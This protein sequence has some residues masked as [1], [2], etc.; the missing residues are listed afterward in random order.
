M[1]TQFSNKQLARW[2]FTVNSLDDFELPHPDHMLE[3]LTGVAADH[4]VYQTEKAT[5]YHYQG[6]L[7]LKK[8]MTKKSLLEAWH[9][10][11]WPM[12]ALTLSIEHSSKGAFNYCTKV[13]TRVAGPFSDKPDEV[14]YDGCDLQCMEVPFP[15]QQQVLDEVA[16]PP[17]DRKILWIHEPT[18]NVGKSKLLKYMRFKGLAVRVP[19]GSA[20]QLRCAM[21]GKGTQRCYVVDLPRVRGKDDSLYD[22][23]AAIEELKNGWIESAFYGKAAELM[24]TPPHVIVVSNDPPRLDL[25]SQDRWA[26]KQIVDKQLVDWVAPPSVDEEAEEADD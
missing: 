18:G 17:N 11:G 12:T 2:C 8:K 20:G 24:M 5:R 9:N 22:L 4:F 3:W 19:M 26:V 14:E 15:W 13:D 21:I 1:A 10:C 23:F 16:Q 25:C 7:A 6:R